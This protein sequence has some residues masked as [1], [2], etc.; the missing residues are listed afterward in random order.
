[1]LSESKTRLP[2][3]A[4]L[5]RLLDAIEATGAKVFGIDILFF[6]TAPADNNV[7]SLR[8]RGLSARPQR[9]TGEPYRQAGV[10]L[11]KLVDFHGYWQ[12]HLTKSEA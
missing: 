4:L 9:R 12:R 10:G 6:P 3:T 7:V 5:A 1:M 8:S 2:S 11:K